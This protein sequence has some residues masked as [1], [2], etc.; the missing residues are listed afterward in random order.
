MLQHK[1][2][3]IFFLGGCCASILPMSLLLQNPLNDFISRFS[4]VCD[5]PSSLHFHWKECKFKTR[6]ITSKG[7]VEYQPE[8]EAKVTICHCDRN[9][10]TIIHSAAVKQ[11]FR[12]WSEGTYEEGRGWNNLWSRIYGSKAP[13]DGVS[14][15]SSTER[16]LIFFVA[17]IFLFPLGIPLFFWWCT[18]V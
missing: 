12:S 2:L 8:M 18:G 6:K 3:I 14:E 7:A 4:E 11:H 9:T 10:H 17:V 5:A 13:F 16:S 1:V 15:W